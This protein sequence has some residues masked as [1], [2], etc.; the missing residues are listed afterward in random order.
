SKNQQLVLFPVH[1]ATISRLRAAL[2]PSGAKDDPKDADLVLDMLVYHRERLRPLE[3][4]TVE[5]R[6][7]R[8]LVE[9]RRSFVDQRTAQSN[10]LKSALK[11]YYPQI[12]DWFDDPAAPLVTAFLSRWPTVEVLQKDRPETLVQFFHANHCRT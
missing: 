1:P 4:D 8:F 10:R 11:Q 12:L 5:T 6:E 3:P 7:L 2:Y 9:Q